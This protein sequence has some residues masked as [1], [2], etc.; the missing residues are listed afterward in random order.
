MNLR[1]FGRTQ[2]VFVVGAL[3]LTLGACSS[4]PADTDAGTSAATG[5]DAP[6]GSSGDGSLSGILAGAGAS[7][8]GAAM[9][10]WI[11]GF[12]D[13]HP[14][15]VLS[16]DPSGS[17]AGREQF[18]AGSVQF[19][20]SDSALKPE[21][22]EAARNTCV[23]G[24]VAELPLYISPIAIVYNLPGLETENLQLSAATIAKIFNGDITKWNDPEIAAENEGVALP[25]LDVIPVN[26][27]DESGTTENFTEYLEAASDG[28]WPHEASGDW[29]VAGGQS[30]QGTSGLVD[31]VAA[32]EGAI[33]YAD[34]SRAGDLGTVALKVGDTYQPFSPEAAAK[35]VD[36]S[37]RAEGAT[38]ERLVVDLDRTTTESG[39]YPLV[40]ISYSVACTVYEDAADAANVKAFLTYVAGEEGQA[41]AA[42]PSVAGSAP[43]SADLRTEV[44]AVVESITSR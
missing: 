20:G 26:R 3:A 35:V 33:G 4:D 28:A 29:P 22:I 37:P 14:D 44:M 23:G 15:V 9:E 41:R 34:A 36:A 30:G 1:R 25:D 38:G 6:S 10:G 21:E 42:E 16:Y 43:I 32:A 18:L 13:A 24:E 7:S 8:Q 19:A 31:T 12:G 40:L 17:G 2:S 27:S 11:A 39:A 5:T